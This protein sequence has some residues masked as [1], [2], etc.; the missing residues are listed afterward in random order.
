MMLG[1]KPNKFTDKNSP[2]VDEGVLSKI[3]H[4]PEA[5]LIAKY[6]LLKERPKSLHGWMKLI[7]QL[8]ECIN[9]LLTLRCVSGHMTP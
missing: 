5:K 6:L 2:I 3:T 8:E 7:T 1:W 9:N 4:I